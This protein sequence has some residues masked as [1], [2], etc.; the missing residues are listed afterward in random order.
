M[1]Y[2]SGHLLSPS[3]IRTSG[4]NDLKVLTRQ[5]S[6]LVKD[7]K[8]NEIAPKLISEG[9]LSEEWLDDVVGEKTKQNQREAIIRNVQMKGPKGLQIFKKALAE[10]GQSHLLDERLKSPQF[11]GTPSHG[12]KVQEQKFDVQNSHTDGKH[13]YESRVSFFPHEFNIGYIE[14]LLEVAGVSSDSTIVSISN[15]HKFYFS[16]FLT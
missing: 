16:I 13:S 14:G 2:L 12:N 5:W 11:Q 6:I 4:E 15:Y 1:P 7:L 8:V 9:I 3:T 10:I